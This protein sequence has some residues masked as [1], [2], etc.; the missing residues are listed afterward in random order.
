MSAALTAD[1]VRKKT[2]WPIGHQV[3]KSKRKYKNTERMNERGGW[4]CV[5][6]ARS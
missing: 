5:A 3:D 4:E 1:D 2:H 6:V